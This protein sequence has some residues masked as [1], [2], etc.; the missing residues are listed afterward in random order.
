MRGPRKF[1][2]NLLQMND[3]GEFVGHCENVPKD[4]GGEQLVST[5]I[6]VP[7]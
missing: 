3:G 5:L 4:G 2:W 7:S 1:L 6:S